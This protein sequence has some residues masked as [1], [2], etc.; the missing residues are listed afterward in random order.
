MEGVFRVLG[1][2]EAEVDG[3]AV[4]PTSAKERTLLAVLVMSGGRLV[5][6]DR[7][8]EEL[9]PELPADRGRRVLHVR[10][11]ALRKL[12]GRAGAEGLLESAASGYR[13][14]ID[15]AMVDA[16]QFEALIERARD[17]SAAGEPAAAAASLREALA[18]WRG[19]PLA[20]VDDCLLLEAEVA[21]LRDARLGAVEDR[22]E[23]DL[24]CGR[25]DAVVSELEG[26]LA[27]NPL[28]ERLWSQRV[29]ALYRCGRQAEALRACSAVRR[30]LVDELGVEPGPGL[31]ALEQA[32]LEQRPELAWSATLPSAVACTPQPA[33]VERALHLS[34]LENA[35]GAVRRE[36]RGL[37]VLVSGEAG[38]GK[39]A[40][41]RH[42]CEEQGSDVRVL[43]GRCDA[44]FTPRPLGPFVD[45][46]ESVGGAFAATVADGGKPFEVAT[47][48][49]RE[50]QP[51]GFTIL[52]LEDLHSADEATLDVVR[53]LS[54][55]VEGVPALVLASY[56]DDVLDRAHPLR[57]VIG[58]MPSGPP[59]IRLAVAPLS[60]AGVDL[61]AGGHPE[62]SAELYEKTGGNPF[63]VT[64]VLAAGSQAVPASVRD[65][66]LARCGGLSPAAHTILEAVAVVPQPTELWLLHRLA[67]A[68]L[69]ELE[70]CLASG[71]LTSQGAAVAFRHEL[72][73]TVV[74][75]SV[76]VH[77]RVALHARAVAGLAAPAIGAPD[78]AR[79]AHHADAAGD[80]EATLRFAPAAGARAAELGAHREAAA[81]FERALRFAEGQ[82]LD[83]RAE[84]LSRR[85]VECF[86]TDDSDDAI[87]ARE[88]ALECYRALGDRIN[89]G[90]SLR[91][92]AR[93]IGCRGRVAESIELGRMAVAVLEQCPPGPELAMAYGHMAAHGADDEDAELAARWGAVALALAEKLD[94]TEVVVH[95][96]NSVGLSEYLNGAPEGRAKLERSL[97]LA[98]QAG[99]DEHAGRAFIHLA[100]AATR[101]RA[102]DAAEQT[103]TLGLEY[104]REHGL[105]LFRVY[106]DAYGART[107][108][109]RGRWPEA[110]TLAASVLRAPL[111]STLPR[112]IAL[113]VLGL[114]R[115]RRGEP[116]ASELLDEASA[117][118]GPTG[119]LQYI[120]PVAAARAEAAWLE[121]RIDDVAAETESAFTVASRRKAR[122][123]WGELACWRWRAGI[124]DAVL[125]D[126][127]EPFALELAGEPA[128]AAAAWAALG[129]PYEADLLSARTAVSPGD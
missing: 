62:V 39:T 116:G 15:P 16:G 108:L 23:A 71:I 10:I 8:V 40:L 104:C 43:W 103:R 57:T 118:A 122:W 79:L 6:A 93:L 82:P 69:D 41:T 83:V 81:Q 95:A 12:L 67:G 34:V 66:V 31:R 49:L 94:E 24:A 19:E 7:L 101:Q 74:E 125:A 68:A 50:L 124:A 96:L 65:A 86:L 110:D 115:V 114:V 91:W 18:L 84:L 30:S 26:L 121:G 56:R 28:R 20:G 42:F 22:I 90:D 37:F 89:E 111:A 87:A 1:P 70:E 109:D 4:T 9:W 100:W 92:L 44:L 75:S 2:L 47:A 52:V 25:H 38:V 105:D 127:P 32:V 117:L 98:Q 129:C 60:P 61:L 128:R 120:G 97:A 53:L 14:A 126:V 54:R 106:L 72:A 77:R 88:A 112:V 76:P 13:L 59:V 35:A 46:A 113:V 58:D 99:L 51:P 48:L 21:R 3:V 33:L 85:S 29:L 55:R 73:R 45:V 27:A 102:H 11:A 36:S 5:T 123:M 17:H 64:E 63:F 80:A 119:E 78:L 107:A